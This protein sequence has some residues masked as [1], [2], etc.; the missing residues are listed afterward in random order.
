MS[1]NE[2]PHGVIGRDEDMLK[3]REFFTKLSTLEETLPPRLGYKENP[4]PGTLFL[5]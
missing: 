4:A 3:R 2:R 1:Y 5:K